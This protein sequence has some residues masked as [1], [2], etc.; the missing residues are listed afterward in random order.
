MFLFIFRFTAMNKQIMKYKIQR[1]TSGLL[2]ITFSPSVFLFIKLI[3]HNDK[4]K[5]KSF[6]NPIRPP[7]AKS[8]NAKIVRN[9]SNIPIS[10]CITKSFAKFCGVWSIFL[11]TNTALSIF[12]A[13]KKIQV[14]VTRE[15]VT[16]TFSQ[17]GNL[18]FSKIGLA[19]RP[20]H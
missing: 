6:V 2:R 9:A 10:R 3:M 16:A 20:T 14:N 17:A 13:L 5:R 7:K 11:I 1:K 19:A 15:K 12:S 8:F 4:S 18:V